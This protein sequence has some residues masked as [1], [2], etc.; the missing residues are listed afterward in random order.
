V[1]LSSEI[2][3]V[4]FG[5]TCRR[6]TIKASQGFYLRLL[7]MVAC[8]VSEDKDDKKTGGVKASDVPRYLSRRV[9]YLGLSLTLFLFVGELG[10]YGAVKPW[11][12]G[13][14]RG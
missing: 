8:G 14:N 13:G 9:T 1:E 5:K 11:H 12:G 7:S 2:E 3:N 6:E 10:A 4:I